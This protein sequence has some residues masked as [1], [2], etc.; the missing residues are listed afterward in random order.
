MSENN[1]V[2]QQGFF[3]KRPVV[4]EAVQ[5]IGVN[6]WQIEEFMN[7]HIQR[8]MRGSDTYEITIPTLEDGSDS[9]V[10]HVAT[11]GD[12]IIKGVAGEFYPCKPDIFHKTYEEEVK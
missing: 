5:F 11:V 12:Y 2:G 9:Q 3:R 10:E 7:T 1:M 6:V 4:V 8:K